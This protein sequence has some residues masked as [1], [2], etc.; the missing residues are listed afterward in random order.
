M[1]VH[2]LVA[3]A[4]H[5]TPNP[6]EVAHH[7]NGNTL[8]NRSI[9]LAWVSQ[10]ENRRL[11]TAPRNRKAR[12]VLQK[13]MAGNVV[14]RWERLKDVPFNRSLVWRACMGKIHKAYG[15]LWSYDDTPNPG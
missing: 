7:I 2:R 9:N 13:D 10:A 6:K 1:L 11:A 4:F 14:N 3:E 15:Y 8:D 12:A 5:G